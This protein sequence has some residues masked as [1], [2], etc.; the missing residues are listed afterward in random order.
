L[1]MTAAANVVT[2]EQYMAT[3]GWTDEMLIE[4]GLAVRPSFA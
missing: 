1:V 3:P 4:Q 2:Y